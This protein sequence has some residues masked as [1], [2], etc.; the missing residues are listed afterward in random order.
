M[1]VL[2]ELRKLGFRVSESG[3]SGRRV[4]SDTCLSVAWYAFALE[5]SSQWLRPPAFGNPLVMHAA[6]SW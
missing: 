6:R 2:S 1:R 3:G 4:A 5:S